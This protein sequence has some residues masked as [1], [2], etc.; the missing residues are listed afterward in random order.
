MPSLAPELWN[1]S[2]VILLCG[3]MGWMMRLVRLLLMYLEVRCA[4]QQNAVIHLEKLGPSLHVLRHTSMWHFHQLLRTQLQIASTTMKRVR[5]PFEIIASS[6]KLVESTDEQHHSRM[7]LHLEVKSDVKCD[8]QVFWQV[9]A[10]ALEGACKSAWSPSPIKQRI[11]RI[12][13]ILPTRAAR[14]AIHAMRSLPRKLY[15]A[16]L[17]KTPHRLLED[18]IDRD[19]GDNGE[20]QRSLKRGPCLPRLFVGGDSFR[21]CSVGERRGDDNEFVVAIPTDLLTSV[22]TEAAIQSSVV[23]TDCENGSPTEVSAA[24]SI[25]D[26]RYTCVVAISSTDFQGN[27]KSPGSTR[28]ARPKDDIEDEVLCQ[29]VAIDFLPTPAKPGRTPIIVKKLHF[30]A[31]NVFSSQVRRELSFSL[32]VSTLWRLT[33]CLLAVLAGDLRALG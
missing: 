21:C 23:A 24:P 11:Q 26:A 16:D 8:V 9:K 19:N 33:F 12:D 13:A 14:T 25:G 29:C 30:T 2:V 31:T 5:V 27:V 15:D 3:L 20:A 1:L 32:S 18:D 10:S 28:I 22:G 4:I 7:N 17:G 6:V